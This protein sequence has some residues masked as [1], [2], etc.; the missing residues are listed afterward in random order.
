VQAQEHEAVRAVLSSAP[1]WRHLHALLAS[2]PEHL[3]P[4]EL[5]QLLHRVPRL[6][7]VCYQ[8]VIL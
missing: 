5:C 3:G 4:S 8:G 2:Y 6:L 7:K 1:T